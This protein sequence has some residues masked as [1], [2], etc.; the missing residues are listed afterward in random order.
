[1]GFNSGFKGLNGPF[2]TVKYLLPVY[3]TRTQFSTSKVRCDIILSIPV[4]SLTS[5]S[6]SKPKMIFSKNILSF[7]FSL[8]SKY[9]LAHIFALAALT[10]TV[11]WSL[12]FAAFGFFFK[13]VIVTWVKS[14]G[15]SP[16]SYTFWPVLRLPSPD[17]LSTSSVVYIIISSSF[18]MP[19][20]L[21]S[22][23]HFTLQNIG[24]FSSTSTSSSVSVRYLDE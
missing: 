7:P 18:L 21:D 10:L 20:L 9:I 13:A 6:S 1:M 22:F 3:E 24:V 14:E 11:R 12:Y 19:K 2:Y 15:H 8:S 16:F 17:I 4:A 23:L 5:F